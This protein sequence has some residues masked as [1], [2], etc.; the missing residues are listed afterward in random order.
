M[1][2]EKRKILGQLE[3][4]EIGDI[5]EEDAYSFCFVIVPEMHQRRCIQRNKAPEDEGVS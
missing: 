4:V 5:K 3:E 1:H 2:I